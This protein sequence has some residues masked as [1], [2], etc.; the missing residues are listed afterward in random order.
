MPPTSEPVGEVCKMALAA[1]KRLSRTYLENSQLGN[2]GTNKL[3]RLRQT[4]CTQEIVGLPDKLALEHQVVH[5]RPTDNHQVLLEK[6]LA[7][8]VPN[9][10]RVSE[11]CLLTS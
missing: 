2:V 3:E 5:G 9:P 11:L 6:D 4:E 8:R 10:N 7:T 1:A